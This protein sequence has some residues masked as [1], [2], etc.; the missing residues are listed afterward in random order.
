M[1]VIFLTVTRNQGLGHFY[2]CKAI[3]QALNEINIDNQFIVD[4]KKN[5]NLEKNIAFLDVFKWYEKQD[6]LFIK[7]NK[8]II[9][10]VDAININY[11]FLKK[12]EK[13]VYKLFYIDDFKNWKHKKI[14]EINWTINKNKIKK[15]NN[16]LIGVKYAALRKSFWY[17]N[18]KKWWNKNF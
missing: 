3:S 9:L 10:F 15:I 14:I 11:N 6:Q 16:K 8:E 4:T 17:N 7:L 1:K 5:I 12:L 18:N 2:R 13:F